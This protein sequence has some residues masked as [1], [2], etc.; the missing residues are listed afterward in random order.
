MRAW[1]GRSGV[2][3]KTAKHIRDLKESNVYVR[4]IAVED[5]G[6]IGDVSVV[7]PLCEALKDRS[8]DVRR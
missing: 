3:K 5:L 1:K 4:R 8:N 2:N 7:Q 6:E